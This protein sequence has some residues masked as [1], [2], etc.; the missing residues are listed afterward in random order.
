MIH[1]YSIQFN[2][3]Q[4]IEVQKKSFDK[5]CTDYKFTII[6]NSI[7]PSITKEI[8][9]ICD[10]L[11]L[12]YI[13]TINKFDTSTNQLH[14]ISHEVGV[15][16]FLDRLKNHHTSN[17]IVML[18]DHDIVFISDFSEMEDLI[19][20]SSILARNQ[21]REHLYYIWPGLSI[22]NLKNCVNINELNLDGCQIIDGQ[23][24]PVADGVFSDVGGHSYHYLKKYKDELKYEDITKYFVE[25][26]EDVNLEHIF[27]HFRD[28]S[29]W[30]KYSKEEWDRKFEKMN[31]VLK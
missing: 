3:P 11:E 2:K 12:E 15:R 24:Q 21:T 31:N 30:S 23:W 18:L 9:S 29:Q 7:D 4:F 16:L 20:K 27:Y 26:H 8:H 22:F 19:N 13:E 28:G 25:S 14:G 5:F 17:D 6:D 10:S 1:I